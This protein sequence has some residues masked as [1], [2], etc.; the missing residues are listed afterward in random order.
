MK[1][2][3]LDIIPIVLDVLLATVSIWS[4]QVRCS[5]IVFITI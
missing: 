4:F 1:C 2:L 5:I 3:D